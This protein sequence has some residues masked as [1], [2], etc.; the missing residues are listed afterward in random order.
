MTPT[1]ARDV[2]GV[3]DAA[4]AEVVGQDAAVG[5]LRASATSPV[6]AY[7][8]VGPSGSGKRAAARAFAATLLAEGFRGEEAERH[9]RLAA[10]ETHPD[11]RI[12][13]SQ[14]A[15]LSI[16]QARDVIQSSARAPIE[17][18]RQITV[19]CEFHR[20]DVAAPALLKTIEEPATTSVFLILADEVTPELVTIASRALRIDFGPVPPAVMAERL[21]AEGVDPD[22]A[23][24]AA[25]A[26]GG[27]L[28]RARLLASDPALDA[29]RTAWLT[30]PE[31]LDGSGAAVA[32]AVGSLRDHIDQAQ[33]PLDTRH[34]EE[35]AE[36]DER[37]ER[38]GVRGQGVKEL[39]D[40]QKREVRRHRTEEVR[41]GL[42]TLADRYRTELREGR[43]SREHADALAAIQ[44]SAEALVRNPNEEL[45]L[46]ALLLRLPE[47]VTAP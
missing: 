38:Y 13:E 43:I 12:V 30:T 18:A 29:R 2:E 36:L 45:L 39:T 34:A 44:A 46:E 37:V 6:P 31:R 15:S 33:A 21:V 40:R 47:V 5:R 41:F 20:V 19:L 23:R 10:A 27:D 32:I 8:F 3:L 35:R 7:L 14:G 25:A 11:L 4:W 17:A 22:R 16:G 42:A 24:Q 26:S 1:P 9:A 28:P